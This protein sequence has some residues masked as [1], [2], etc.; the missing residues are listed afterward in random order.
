[1]GLIITIGTTTMT[2]NKLIAS[3]CLVGLLL[4]RGEYS[5]AQSLD[6]VQLDAPPDVANK[7][8]NQSLE[9]FRELV[10]PENAKAYGFDA[11]GA[12][13]SANIGSPVHE[14]VIGLDSLKKWNGENVESLIKPT[15]RLI[16]PIVSKD[17][18]SRSSVTLRLKDGGWSPVSFGD[19]REAQIRSDIRSTIDQS[20]PAGAPKPQVLQVRVPALNLNFLAQRKDNIVLFTSLQSIP[21][22]DIKTGTT[23]PAKDILTRVQS[24]AIKVNSDVPN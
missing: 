6:Q 1:M 10:T 5:Q 11:P 9:T 19:A 14:A 17:G 22:I 12:V 23:E 15:G 18:I 3:A 2:S 4:L 8:A 7:A 24:M 20:A 21:S 13:A 16:Y